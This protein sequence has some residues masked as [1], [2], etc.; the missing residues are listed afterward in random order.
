MGCYNLVYN[1]SIK[2]HVQHLKVTLEV[3]KQHWLLAKLSKCR[4]STKEVSY[5]GHLISF[6]GVRADPNN[7]QAME[8]WPFSTSLKA[9]RGFLGLTGY[10]MRLTRG[11]IIPARPS[12]K[13]WDCS[14]IDSA[15]KKRP[16]CV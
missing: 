7:V 16:V 12:T 2:E 5:L 14:H 13:E 11:Y 6:E 1:K 8:E 9:L 4:F 10:Y 15:F 3:L